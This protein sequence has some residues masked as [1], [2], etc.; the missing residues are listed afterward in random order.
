[1][2]GKDAEENLENMKDLFKQQKSSSWRSPY[3]LAFCTWFPAFFTRITHCTSLPS[4]IAPPSPMHFLYM[5]RGWLW[6]GD[7]MGDF[8]ST[9]LSLALPDSIRANTQVKEEAWIAIDFTAH[10]LSSSLYQ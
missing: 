10:L 4:Q 1:M 6:C 2:K 8:H 5:P 3:Y 7:L 9:P